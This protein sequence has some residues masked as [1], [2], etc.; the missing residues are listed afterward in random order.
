MYKHYFY[1]YVFISSK[2]QK[3]HIL[4]NMQKNIY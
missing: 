2:E 3:I 4:D 1:F